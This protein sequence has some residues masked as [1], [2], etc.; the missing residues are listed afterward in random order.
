MNGP[1]GQSKLVAEQVGVGLGVVGLEGVQV[2]GQSLER[3]RP[4]A[5]QD[6]AERA[7]SGRHVGRQEVPLHLQVEE[8]VMSF[9]SA[10]QRRPPWSGSYRHDAVVDDAAH[11]DVV[12]VAVLDVLRQVARGP[13]VGA[14]GRNQPLDRQGFGEDRG[15][16]LQAGIEAK[17]ERGPNPD[18]L[19]SALKLEDSPSE[20]P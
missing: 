17:D 18:I 7:L 16:Q 20:S 15:L 19:P 14:G 2:V 5:Q 12:Q 9:G 6:V 13:T 3:V 8:D 1:G 11:L 4:G 10:F